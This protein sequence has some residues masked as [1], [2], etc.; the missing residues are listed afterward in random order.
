MATKANGKMAGVVKWYDSAKGYGFI[1][2]TD[3]DDVFVHVSAVRAAGHD[4][5]MEGQAV[6]FELEQRDRGR[7]AAAN[8]QIG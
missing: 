3:G 6:K 5:L 4:S 2:R 8:L 7:Y 1:S